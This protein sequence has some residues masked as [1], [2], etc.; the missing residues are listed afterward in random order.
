M[1]VGVSREDTVKPTKFRC[2]LPPLPTTRST[3]HLCWVTTKD[4]ATPLTESLKR[5]CTSCKQITAHCVTI[6]L[7]SVILD[8][9]WWQFSM[10]HIYHDT[11]LLVIAL[12]LCHSDTG[13]YFLCLLK[14]AIGDYSSFNSYPPPPGI[15]SCLHP[16]NCHVVGHVQAGLLSLW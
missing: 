4:K 12:V 8:F 15:K 16:W 5:C 2:I 14:W 7:I 9:N 11:N 10:S 13:H 6:I 1:W 3:H